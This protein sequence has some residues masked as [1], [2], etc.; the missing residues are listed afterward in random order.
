MPYPDMNRE[1]G[2]KLHVRLPRY[3]CQVVYLT[4]LAA[5]Y[6]SALLLSDPEFREN[7]EY[8]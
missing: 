3:F 1:I 7:Q 4:T 6:K 8:C 5:D 2:E